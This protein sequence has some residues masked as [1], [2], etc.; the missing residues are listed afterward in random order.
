MNCDN[1]DDKKKMNIVDRV[2]VFLSAAAWQHGYNC[3]PEQLEKRRQWGRWRRK[4]KKKKKKKEQP[5]H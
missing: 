3:T 1:N 4:K 2:V 5:V